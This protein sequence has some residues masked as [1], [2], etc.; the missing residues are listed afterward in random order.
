MSDFAQKRNACE[1]YELLSLTNA[2]Q[3]WVTCK[4]ENESDVWLVHARNI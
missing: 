1:S 3:Y 2:S 4:S